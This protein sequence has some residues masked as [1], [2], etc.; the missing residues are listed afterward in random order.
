MLHGT[1][2]DSFQK[3]SS[4]S[5]VLEESNPGTVTH[6][7]VDSRNR[8]HYFFLAFDASI[9]SYMHYLRPVICVDGSYLKGPYKGTLLLATGKDVNKQIYPLAWEIVDGETNGSWMWFLSNLKELIGDSDV[10]IFVFDRKN[11][12]S[13]AI[14][15]LNRM[16][17][18]H[19]NHAVCLRDKS[20]Y[21]LCSPYYTSKYWWGTNSEA[22]KQNYS[23]DM[24][25]DKNLHDPSFG[26]ADV[27]HNIQHDDIHHEPSAL[28]NNIVDSLIEYVGAVP[29]D[30]MLED[31]L[32]GTNGAN[33]VDINERMSSHSQSS[34]TY[35]WITS[36]N[37]SDLVEQ[38][39]FFSKKKQYSKIRVL[40]LQ[41]KFL[42]KVSRPS[43][44]LLTIV[45]ADNNCK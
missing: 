34:D 26:T 39:I 44:K 21:D 35:Q 1:P 3:L 5:H 43:L 12:I 41:D 40:A 2:G 20:L 18:I 27:P 33:I 29:L 16:P 45:Y 36:V 17:C 11:S 4:Y 28:N 25:R 19:V 38:Q 30:E 23:V 31:P 8:F 42:F 6:I 9:H 15:H 22:S 14:A 32:H 7:E 37:T 10:L 13:N 24:E